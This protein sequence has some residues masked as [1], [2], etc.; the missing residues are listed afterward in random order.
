MW[1]LKSSS[2]KKINK[3]FDHKG[4]IQSLSLSLPHSFFLSLPLSPSPPLLILGSSP[5]LY[6]PD[7]YFSILLL[8]PLHLCFFPPFPTLF[9]FYLLFSPPYLI[10]TSKTGRSC[11]DWKTRAAKRRIAKERQ[12]DR[13]HLTSHR[14]DRQTDRNTDKG[15]LIQ[16]TYGHGAEQSN[17]TW[18]MYSSLHLKHKT[19]TG[20][21]ANFPLRPLR[22]FLSCTYKLP[23]FHSTTA[24][25]VC[26][27]VC[28]LMHTDGLVWKGLSHY[29]F[30]VVSECCSL[31]VWLGYHLPPQAYFPF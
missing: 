25:C 18:K 11:F 24:M 8:K 22:H 7:L 20:T 12:T 23:H 14:A 19:R 9:S 30:V 31:W 28:F 17:T 29:S 15:L 4:P 16:Q 26:E 2:A 10:Y 21:E 5:Q 3:P 13:H 27:S 6:S 1:L